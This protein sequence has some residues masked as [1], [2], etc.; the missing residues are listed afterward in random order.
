MKFNLVVY[1]IIGRTKLSSSGE[2]EAGYKKEIPNIAYQF[3]RDIK[4]E[5]GYRTTIFRRVIV[6]GSEDITK[7]IREIENRP[8]P[9]M[10]DVF[11]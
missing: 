4:R 11:W 2:F 7:E 1:L 9:S 10:E 5:T 6:N 3:I 8:I